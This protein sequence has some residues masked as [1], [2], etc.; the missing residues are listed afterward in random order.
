M[1]RLYKIEQRLSRTVLKTFGESLVLNTQHSE[2]L[3]FTG[4]FDDNEILL[5]GFETFGYVVSVPVANWSGKYPKSGKSS[6]TRLK[7]NNEHKVY[8]S[9]VR[10][11]A[12]LIYIVG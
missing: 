12:L 2:P 7:T 5:D 9:T 3:Q 8:K 1:S 4:V 11:S 6:I 10:G